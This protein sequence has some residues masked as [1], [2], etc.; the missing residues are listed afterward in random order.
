MQSST[1]DRYSSRMNDYICEDCP[2]CHARYGHLRFC[3]TLNPRTKE[4]WMLTHGLASK[5]DR[6]RAHGIGVVLA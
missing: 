2:Y 4:A 3:P 5:A 6:V 1:G